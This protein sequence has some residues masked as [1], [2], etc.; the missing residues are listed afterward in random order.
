[1]ATVALYLSK[2][3]ASAIQTELKCTF[4]EA[5]QR[6]GRDTPGT[7]P[8]GYILDVIA[9]NARNQRLDLI[10]ESL[11]N[12]AREGG[13]LHLYQEGLEPMS[14]W[15][16]FWSNGAAEPTFDHL[17]TLVIPQGSVLT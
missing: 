8:D 10:V 13:T 7:Y 5:R 12:F 11:E 3:A 17:V 16:E 15:M 9:A 14:A 6:A 4:A 1:M 2:M